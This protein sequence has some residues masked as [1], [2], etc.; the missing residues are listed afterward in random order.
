M[1]GNQRVYQWSAALERPDGR[2]VL[3]GVAYAEDEHFDAK[4]RALEHY[5][6]WKRDAEALG[7]IEKVV[8]LRRPIVPWEIA[9]VD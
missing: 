5:H 2:L 6:A 3:V 4:S 8:F 9:D 1:I 7:R